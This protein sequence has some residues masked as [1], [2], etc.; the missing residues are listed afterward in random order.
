MES[1]TKSPTKSPRK[2]MRQNDDS[3]T[4]KA[5]KYFDPID[6]HSDENGKSS[7]THHCI[8]CNEPC[9]GSKKWNLASH[10]LHRHAKEYAEISVNETIAVRRLKL[11]HS[12]TEMVTVNGH[13]FSC[14]HDSGFQSAIRTTLDELQA[15]QVPLNLS[16]YN[17]TVIKNQISQTAAKI[18]AKIQSEVRD[19]PLSLLVDIVTKHKRS[20]MGVS[21]Q[22]NFNGT[23]KVR[24]IGFIELWD[25][26][27]GKYLAEV[28]IRR[29]DLLEI[30]LKQI[31]TITADNGKNVLKMVRD[32][33]EYLN[34]E[35]NA[36]QQKTPQ[37]SN[38]QN[39]AQINSSDDE[40]T[41]TAIIDLL[42]DV[43]EL[44][45]EDALEIVMDEVALD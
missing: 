1:P 25:R 23:L 7:K 33:T 35:I 45:D 30:K 40:Q 27:T 31:F 37:K 2:R 41:D 21:L 5:L 34:A 39:Q 3:I 44:T 9:N 8:L 26:H 13:P 22:Y 4:S 36:Q 43:H 6:V 28:I 38:T 10:L 24:S 12:C 20:I 15:A 14:L 11:L 16:D 17:L 18:R 29:L 42:K 32:L 19:R